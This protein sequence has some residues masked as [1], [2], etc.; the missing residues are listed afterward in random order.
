[1]EDLTSFFHRY[2]DAHLKLSADALEPFFHL[3]CLINDLGGVHAISSK[4]DLAAY[5]APFV[6]ELAKARLALCKA[7]LTEQHSS[8]PGG[9]RAVVSFRFGNEANDLIFDCDYAFALMRVDQ[10]WKIVFAQLD[11]IRYSDLY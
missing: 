7:M 6:E 4:H 10:D 1:M 9:A 2:G 8:L 5:H 11:E 3:P